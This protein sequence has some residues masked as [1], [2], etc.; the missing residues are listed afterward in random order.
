MGVRLASEDNPSKAFPLSISGE[1]LGLIYDG[2]KWT[3]KMPRDN[4]DRLLVLVG[5]GIKEGVLLNEEAMTLTGKLNHYSNLVNGKFERCLVIHL[6]QDKAKK[7]DKVVIN[8]QAR[9]QL[10]W[11]VLNLRALSMD[12]AFLSDPDGYFPRSAIMLFPAAALGATSGGRGGDA[13]IRI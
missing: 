13:A 11:W 10:V 12:G 7:K 4:S 6:V 2:G 8:K 3:W 5:K 9:T 1:I